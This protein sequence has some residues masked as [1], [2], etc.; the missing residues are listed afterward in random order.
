VEIFGF[1]V[2]IYIA[3]RKIRAISEL[4][5]QLAFAADMSDCESRLD[6]PPTWASRRSRG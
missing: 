1:F 4:G 2:S 3:L 6:S 5:H